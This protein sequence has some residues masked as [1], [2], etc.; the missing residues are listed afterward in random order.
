MNAFQTD[1]L[2]DVWSRIQSWP[3]PMRLSLASRILHSLEQEQLK[4]AA[5]KTLRDLVGMWDTGGPALADDEVDRVVAEERIRP[6][7][8]PQ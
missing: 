8:T 3:E 1:E 2:Q 5:R 7:V 6:S 4:R